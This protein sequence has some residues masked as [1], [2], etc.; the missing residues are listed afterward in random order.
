V[1]VDVGGDE[2]RRYDVYPTLARSVTVRMMRRGEEKKGCVVGSDIFV[3]VC[4]WGGAL[5]REGGREE[6][7]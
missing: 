1:D 5:R 4:L 7:D 3:C 6:G 2:R